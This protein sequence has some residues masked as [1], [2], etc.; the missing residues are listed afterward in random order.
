MWAIPTNYLRSFTE[1]GMRISFLEILIMRISSIIYYLLRERGLVDFLLMFNSFCWELRRLKYSRDLRRLRQRWARYWEVGAIILLVLL[2]K[3]QN[4]Y[5]DIINVPCHFP[6]LL[7]LWV[8][9]SGHTLNRH[10][11]PYATGPCLSEYWTMKKGFLVTRVILSACAR[12]CEGIL[13][14]QLSG[15]NS[16]LAV[17]KSFKKYFSLLKKKKNRLCYTPST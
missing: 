15:R 4:I 6:C 1:A 2:G 7:T 17:W 13:H 9:Y 14:F 11:K 16:T 12:S 3:L 5:P 10:S 8:P